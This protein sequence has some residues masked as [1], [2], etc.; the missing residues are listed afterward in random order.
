MIARER[1]PIVPRFSGSKRYA[2]EVLPETRLTIGLGIMCSDGIVLAVD[3]QYSQDPIKYRG[4]KLF[5]LKQG[6]NYTIL[7]AAANNADSAKRG[8][9]IIESHLLVFEHRPATMDEIKSWIETSLKKL[10]VEYIDLAKSK[11]E[12]DALHCD[13]L[14]AI[15]VQGEGLRL[16]RSNRNIFLEEETQTSIGTGQYFSR[17]LHELLVGPY[18]TGRP[19]ANEAVCIAAYIVN[20]AKDYVQGIGKESIISVLHADGRWTNVLQ[21]DVNGLVASFKDLAEIMQHCLRCLDIDAVRDDEL[22]RFGTLLLESVKRFRAGQYQR[23]E[24]E[25]KRQASLRGPQDPESTTADQSHPQPSPESPE[26][27]DES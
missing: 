17:Y 8:I 21:P 18:I 2:W 14:F 24:R 25:A 19:T 1:F 6:S 7:A 10:F 15:W 5:P 12:R 3:N 4:K 11:K 27:S 20:A 23:K 22:D 13:F 26:G 16:F 9:E